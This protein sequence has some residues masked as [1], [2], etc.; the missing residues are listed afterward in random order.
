MKKILLVKSEYHICFYH[1]IPQKKYGLLLNY[2]FVEDVL[3]NMTT[4]SCESVSTS[5]QII[6]FLIPSI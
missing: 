3:R 5:D 1:D 4:L 6:I 2:V